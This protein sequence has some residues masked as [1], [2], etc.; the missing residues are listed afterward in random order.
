M[1]LV[2]LVFAGAQLGAANVGVTSIGALTLDALLTEGNRYNSRATRY[3]V[4]NGAPITDHISRDSE[5]LVISGLVTSASVQLF[6]LRGREKLISARDALKNIYLAQST[7]MIVT[8]M[9]VYSNMVMEQCEI[10]RKVDDGGEVL[11]INCK[12]VRIDV[13]QLMKATLPPANVTSEGNVKGKAGQTKQNAGKATSSPPAEST[14][15][16]GASILK[17]LF[18]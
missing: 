14:S 6:G 8:G 9:D 16:K 13:A 11:D 3:P 5:V 18:G 12:F 7:V 4:E 2:S 1:S 15:E 10:D 17:G